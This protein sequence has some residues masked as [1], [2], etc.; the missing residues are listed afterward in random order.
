MI[1]IVQLSQWLHLQNLHQRRAQIVE[2]GLFWFLDREIHM[3]TTH[4]LRLLARLPERLATC[5]P[6]S[7]SVLVSQLRLRPN[8]QI[9]VG[10]QSVV[11]H[12]VDFE[13][14]HFHRR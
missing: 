10:H 2:E 12:L 7:P 4:P 9:L 5:L 11:S 3:P 1:P 6:P 14:F 8:H 13:C